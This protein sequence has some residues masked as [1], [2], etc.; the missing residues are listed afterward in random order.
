M[1]WGSTAN[2]CLESYDSG[3]ARLLFPANGE[4][5]VATWKITDTVEVA[6]GLTQA[7]AK[8]IVDTINESTQTQ[9]LTQH[10]I[11]ERTGESGGYSVRK[12]THQVE[13]LGTE[14]SGDESSAES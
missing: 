4:A 9:Q 1:A 6:R 12:T 2:W 11:M 7:A 14:K 5:A 13:F 10:G 3:V 8:R